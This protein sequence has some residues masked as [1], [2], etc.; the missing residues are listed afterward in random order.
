MARFFE[1]FNIV[2]GDGS[3]S[4]GPQPVD[5]L[6]CGFVIDTYDI[7]EPDA[8]EPL[9]DTPLGI[10]A[11]PFAI[12]AYQ[13]VPTRC[14]PAEI[15][16]WVDS[17]MHLSTEYTVTKSLWYGANGNTSKMYMH[18]PD[19]EVVDRGANDIK[20]L[21]ACLEAVY[22]KAPMI[23]PTIHLGFEAAMSM[24]F[25]LDTLKIPF[26][27]APGYPPDAI[28]VSG[29][30]TINL[31]S[32]QTIASVNPANNR[33]QLESSRLARIVFDPCMVVRAAD[34]GTGS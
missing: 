1:T 7:C 24:Q 9:A 30:I 20:T 3:W 32:V 33:K 23:R 31:G 22:E 18:D 25:G 28:A 14:A 16:E 6:A 26:V 10:D 19:I 4:S 12:K 17:A 15:L 11:T 34:S 2:E 29:P 21:G 13:E 27:V 8:P 5:T